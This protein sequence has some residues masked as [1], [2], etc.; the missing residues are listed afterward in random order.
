M[1]ERQGDWMDEIF[2]NYAKSGGMN[3]LPGKGKPLD[4]ASGDALH[5]VM[6]EAHVLPSWLELQKKIRN[7]LELML[8]QMEELGSEPQDVAI[9]ELNRSIRTYNAMVPNALLQKGTI[10]KENIRA[11]WTKWE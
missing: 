9:E 4:V 2:S 3:E 10:T 5:S 11:Q 8:R 7:Q 6:K 1:S